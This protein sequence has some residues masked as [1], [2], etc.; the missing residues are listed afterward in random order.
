[1][2]LA[3]FYRQKGDKDKT[4]RKKSNIGRNLAIAG[5]VGAGLIGGGLAVKKKLQRVEG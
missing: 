2:Y 4:P 1:M 5:V 3:N